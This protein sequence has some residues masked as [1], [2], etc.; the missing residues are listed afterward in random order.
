MGDTFFFYLLT[1]QI[2][3]NYVVGQLNNTLN[4]TEAKI[5]HIEL[6]EE[7][8]RYYRRKQI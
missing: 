8:Q 2:R 4:T 7:L 1:K 6:M 3:G 5:N